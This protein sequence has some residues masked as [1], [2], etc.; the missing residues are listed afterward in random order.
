MRTNK[1][2][3]ALASMLWMLFVAAAFVFGDASTGLITIAIPLLVP[4]IKSADIS[5]TEKLAQELNKVFGDLS[6]GIKAAIA[7]EYKEK[8]AMSLTE[9]DA[10]LK[11]LGIEEKTLADITSALTDHGLAIDKGLAQDAAKFTLKGMMKSAF[12]QEGLADQIKDAYGKQGNGLI[13]V[14]KDVGNITISQVTTTTGG[15][16]LLDMLNADEISDIRLSMPF[17]ED[18]SNVSNT[19]KPVFTYVDYIPGEGDVAFLAEGQEKSQIDFDIQVKTVAPVKAA[20]YEILTEESITDIPRLES[21]AR[22]IL[23]RK[24]LLKRQNGILFGDGIGANPTGVTKIASLFNPAT[25]VGE[26]VKAPNLHDVIIALANQIYTTVS[27]T[28]D[29]EYF[30]N[31]VFVNPADFAALRISK[32]L[33]GQYLF[34]SFTIFN[35]KTIDGIRVV[36]K[37]KIPAGKILIGDFKKLNIVDYVAYSVRIGWINDQFI[38]N[39][40]TMLGEGRFFVY[41]KNLDQRAFVYDDIANVIAGIE[42]VPA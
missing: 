13:D 31:V 34:P 7:D 26:K 14:T 38:K 30:P 35:D 27:Y 21:N 42:E 32:D 25:W 22:G 4:V 10:K 1:I 3:F 15:N 2:I 40:F 12:S 5:D 24:Y 36:A 19:S 41:V 23:F 11:K 29:V 39:L 20:G 16:A 18:F 9:L 17:I 37:N 6:A 8:G 33:D 28:D